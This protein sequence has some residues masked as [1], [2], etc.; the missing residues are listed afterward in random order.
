MFAV[1]GCAAFLAFASLILFVG[2]GAQAAPAAATTY[3][4]TPLGD[5]GGGQSIARDIN[6]SGQVVGQSQNTSGQAQAF[7]WENGKMKSLGTLGGPTSFARGINKDGQVV[8]FSR[9][10]S[11]NN[12]VRAFLAQNG[13]MTNLGTLAGFSSSE[14][15]HI[16]DS[17][18][19]VGRSFNSSSQ[20]R[21]VLWKNGQPKD[22]G[23]SLNTPYSEAWGINNLGQVVG[24]AGSVDQ[25]AKAYL[26]DNN[27]GEVTDLDALLDRLVFPYPY[28]EAA[29]INDHGQVVGW[30]Y[31]ITINDPPSTP[32]GPEGKAFLYEKDADG[33]ATVLPLNPLDGDLYSRARDIDESGRVVG[34]SRGTNGNDAEQF[35]AALWE[36]GK[37]TDLN[38]LIPAESRWK[39]TDPYDKSGWKL[40]DPY[41]INES[42]QIVGTGY[43]YD[44]DGNKGQLQAFLLTPNDATAP[45]TTATTSP[46]PNAAGWNKENVTVTLDATDEGGSNVEGITYSASGAESI[47]VSTVPGDSTKISIAA[48]GETT[49]TYYA[50]DHAGNA[51]EPRTLT[52]RLDKTAPGVDIASPANSAEY[53]L[54]EVVTADYACS[55]GGSGVDS[56]SGPV[57]AGANV[58]TASIG[59]KTFAVEGKDR[60][61]NVTSESNVYSVIYDFGGFFSPVDNPDVLNRVQAGSA[62]PVKFDL[63]GDQGLDIFAEGYPKSRQIDCDSTASVDLIEQTVAARESALSY[64]PATDQYIYVWKTQKAWAGT[65]RQFIMKLDDGTTHSANFKFRG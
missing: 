31:R 59:Q 50:T 61:G 58:D 65:C 63:S 28:S 19:A 48:E 64:D 8:G 33:T 24:E 6:N 16:N 11:T 40:T 53:K 4:V 38:D 42:G 26:Y 36:D 5:L 60:A 39:L 22:L 18:V 21:A 44:K 55:D 27:T 13:Q 14:A 45:D 52:V 62:I 7:L 34:W 20:G 15:W 29:G 10:S 41:A 56:C 46:E 54:G 23:T 1:T 3:T 17:G 49:I 30:S 47:D 32:P 35:S 51:E 43:H 25:Q 12:Q 37:V 9:I 2:I 57:P